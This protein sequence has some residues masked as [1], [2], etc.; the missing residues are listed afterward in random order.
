MAQKKFSILPPWENHDPLKVGTL[1]KRHFIPSS[2]H[3]RIGHAWRN[4]TQLTLLMSFI[5]YYNNPKVG[6]FIFIFLEVVGVQSYKKRNL[7]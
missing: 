1:K 5:V 3:C 2:S 7:R 6:L 4:L